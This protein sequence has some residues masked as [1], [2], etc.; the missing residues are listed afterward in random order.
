MGVEHTIKFVWPSCLSELAILINLDEPEILINLDE[1]EILCYEPNMFKRRILEALYIQE[2][3]PSLNV[4]IQSYKLH[5]FEVP[6]Y[7]AEARAWS[8]YFVA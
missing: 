3:S 8:L 2:H 5:L 6:T 4:Q 1:P 7:V